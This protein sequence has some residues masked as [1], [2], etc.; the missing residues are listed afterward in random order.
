MSL[1]I[2]RAALITAPV[3]AAAATLLLVVTGDQVS[4]VLVWGGSVTLVAAL[5]TVVPER[6]WRIAIWTC[7]ALVLVL[8]AL[9]ILSIG[10]YFLPA[11]AAL[12]VA[13]ITYRP[14]E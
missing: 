3:F 1:L 11:L 13:G 2:A 14:R 7:S 6:Y 5:P 8:A 9:S 4:N 12:V 10:A